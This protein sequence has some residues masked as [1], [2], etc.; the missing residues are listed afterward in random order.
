[1]LQKTT[2]IFILILYQQG[3]L[4][5]SL[6]IKNMCRKQ[7]LKIKRL[8]GQEMIE[9]VEQAPVEGMLTRCSTALI[10][11]S[12]ISSIR[13]NKILGRRRG[14]Q[15]GRRKMREGKRDENVLFSKC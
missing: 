6:Q 11:S 15:K 14:I 13:W 1:M 2:K 9:L 7:I 5:D 4:R 10:T 3:N 8:K 12:K